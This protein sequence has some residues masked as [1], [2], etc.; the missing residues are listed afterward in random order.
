MR[1]RLRTSAA[2]AALLLAGCSTR[3]ALPPTTRV[4]KPD[5]IEKWS[6]RG[7]Y[8]EI[9]DDRT[10]ELARAM[11]SHGCATESTAQWCFAN[12]EIVFDADAGSDVRH[13]AITRISFTDGGSRPSD[14][15][16]FVDRVAAAG[17][18]VTLSIDRKADMATY[19][20]EKFNVTL[21]GS[22]VTIR[23]NGCS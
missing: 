8:L 10:A 7:D 2:L 15:T 19:T 17:S 18:R 3:A 22:N 5:V 23:K 1:N 16:A 9:R 4:P 20:D 14:G 11:S 6:R 12:I 21:C 13:G